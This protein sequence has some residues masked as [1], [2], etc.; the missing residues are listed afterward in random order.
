MLFGTV[1]PGDTFNQVSVAVPCHRSILL[2]G[3]GPC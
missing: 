2:V 3:P 1:L